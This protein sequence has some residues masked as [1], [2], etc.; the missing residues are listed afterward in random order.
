[1]H[2][3]L[4]ELARATDSTVF[5]VL[6]A[7]LAALL[8]G[9]DLA[10][11]TPVA[12]RP[13]EALDEVIGFFVNTVVLRLDTTGDPTFA[14]LLARARTG[15]LAAFDHQSVPFDRV[16]AAVNPERRAGRHPLFQVMLAVHAATEGLDLPGLDAS[17]ERL[18]T[19]TAQFD[20]TVDLTE[21]L[22]PAGAPGGL[23]GWLEYAT[24]RYDEAT[25]RRLTEQF[26]KVLGAIV[27]DPAIRL[28]KLR[29]QPAAAHP[30]AVGGTAP[31]QR[32]PTGSSREQKVLRRI[33]AHV[34]G[35]TTVGDHDSFFDLGGHSLLATRLISQVRS[36]LGVEIDMATLF[37][38][39]TVADLTRRLADAQQARPPLRPRSAPEEIR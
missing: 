8:P 9:T 7:A 31:W 2:Q 5:M 19:A 34:L 36:A 17:L 15:D 10:I 35:V 13:D 21:T 3:R 23:T 39:P 22:D 12:N 1:M 30:F 20:L 25:A 33:F 37:E 26:A 18:H 27:A 32:R 24:D 6:H 29:P 14:E 16:V 28:G 38:A 4:T 11:G